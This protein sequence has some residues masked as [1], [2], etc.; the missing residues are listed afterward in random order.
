MN[1]TI[2][3]L[4]LLILAGALVFVVSAYQVIKLLRESAQRK[5]E[6]SAAIIADVAAHRGPLRAPGRR[7]AIDARFI[8]QSFNRLVHRE[9][10]P[11]SIRFFFCRA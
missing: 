5:S 8:A 11:S 7:A 4:N 1:Q 2:S 10:R 3:L 6:E 9:I